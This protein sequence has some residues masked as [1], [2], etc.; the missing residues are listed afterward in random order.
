MN[1]RIEGSATGEIA[2]K[3]LYLHGVTVVANC[4]QCGGEVR[5][6]LGERYL[7]YPKLGTAMA[8]HFSH[9]CVVGERYED[10]EWDEMVVLRVTL[11]P[12]A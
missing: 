7:S 8:Y 12:A 11:E 4:P 3:R 9:E 1:L 2:E 10:H 6:D 5:H